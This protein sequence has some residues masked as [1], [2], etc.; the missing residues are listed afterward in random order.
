MT[1]AIE[2]GMKPEL[3]IQLVCRAAMDGSIIVIGVIQP[4][5]RG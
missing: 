1:L 5:N 3:L 4:F 2:K